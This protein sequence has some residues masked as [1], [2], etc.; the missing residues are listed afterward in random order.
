MK[1]EAH[2]GRKVLLVVAA[3]IVGISGIAAV[4]EAACIVDKFSV[5]GAAAGCGVGANARCLRCAAVASH[6]QY[7]DYRGAIGW[8]LRD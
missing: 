8:Y 2:R 1:S 3:I 7:G 5:A 6:I 4:F